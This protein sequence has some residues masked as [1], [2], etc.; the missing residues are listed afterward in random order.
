MFYNERLTAQLEGENDYIGRQVSFYFNQICIGLSWSLVLV[1]N[2]PTL[3]MEA[4][5]KS[6]TKADWPRSVSESI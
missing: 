6:L 1:L 3:S 5:C 2:R 4:K